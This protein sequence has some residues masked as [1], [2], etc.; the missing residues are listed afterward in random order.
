MAGL[1]FDLDC[2]AQFALGKALAP[3]FAASSRVQPFSRG[4]TVRLYA[5]A[6]VLAAHCGLN[7]IR[8]GSWV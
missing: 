7:G 5:N 4:G 6:T 8:W 2:L 3:T 1:F